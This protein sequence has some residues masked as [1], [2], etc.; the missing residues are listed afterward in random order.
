MRW[1]F[2]RR[3]RSALDGLQVRLI[4][5]DVQ[6][7]VTRDYGETA[8]EK[9]NELLFHLGLATISIVVLIAIA[10]GWREAVVTLGGDPDHDPAHAVRRA[11]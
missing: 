3:S 11:T 5:A 4:P 9:A 10:I 8:N 6:V 2:R 1:W 7:T